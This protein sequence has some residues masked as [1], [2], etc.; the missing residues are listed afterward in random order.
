MELVSTKKHSGKKEIMKRV[1]S[2]IVRGK[3]VDGVYSWAN[4]EYNGNKFKIV[5][6]R[7][8]YDGG[9]GSVIFKNGKIYTGSDKTANTRY[10]TLTL[11]GTD[12]LFEHQLL[13]VALIPG[14]FDKL[15]NTDCVINHKTI[16]FDSVIA[17]EAYN[18][19]KRKQQEAFEWGMDFPDKSEFF[20]FQPPCNVWDLE[21]CTNSQN[22]RHSVVVEDCE[23]YAV[24]ICP[25]FWIVTDN[26]IPN[27]VSLFSIETPLELM[28]MIMIMTAD[29]LLQN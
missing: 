10:R 20:T 14:A 4:F 13:A 23:L 2:T 25:S 18:E 28:I 26:P 19:F 12:N 16:H 21:L 15:Y 24:A 9:K 17:K 7:S 5:A 1:D 11:G 8:S 27:P 22:K 3:I 6:D 29:V